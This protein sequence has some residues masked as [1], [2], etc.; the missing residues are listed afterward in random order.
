MTVPIMNSLIILMMQKR[1]MK[2]IQ[3]HL[4]IQSSTSLK[5]LEDQMDFLNSRFVI[6]RLYQAVMSGFSHIIL[7]QN[8]VLV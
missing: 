5:I 3:M 2:I 6:I 8:Q 4:S 1:K 7:S